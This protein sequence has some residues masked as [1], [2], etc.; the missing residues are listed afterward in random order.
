MPKLYNKNIVPA[1]PNP[2]DQY[3][4]SN[5]AKLTH[6]INPAG[7]KGSVHQQETLLVHTVWTPYSAGQFETFH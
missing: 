4:I 6:H 5:K 3:Q 7:S 2:I 1:E